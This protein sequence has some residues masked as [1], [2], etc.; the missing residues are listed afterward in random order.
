LRAQAS[1]ITYRRRYQ[2]GPDLAGALRLLVTDLA[3]PRALAFPLACLQ[4]QL[5]S[6]PT[7]SRPV[8]SNEAYPA[9]P[10]PLHPL[11]QA[12]TSIHAK[13]PL[14]LNDPCPK[15]ELDQ[16][17]RRSTLQTILPAKVT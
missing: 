17:M 12:E 2:P 10:A 14:T 3:Y 7:W 1:L 6:L 8:Q 13:A 4:G 11:W 9:L 16:R 15:H 5:E